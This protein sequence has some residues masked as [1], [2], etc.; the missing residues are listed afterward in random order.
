LQYTLNCQK[1]TEWISL[2]FL[3]RI[4]SIA[5]YPQSFSATSDQEAIDEAYKNG[6]NGYFVKPVDHK[7]FAEK[8]KILKKC[9]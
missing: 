2:S 5:K 8:I 1:S 7:E 9:Y 4:Q 3:K 6:A